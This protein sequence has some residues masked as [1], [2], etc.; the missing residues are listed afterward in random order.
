M[1]DGQATSILAMCPLEI[2]SGSLYA[3]GDMLERKLADYR[4]SSAGEAEPAGAAIG[5]IGYE[6]EFVFG[7]YRNL[8]VYCHETGLWYE[9]GNPT[10]L[11][12][13]E[14]SLAMQPADFQN[15]VTQDVF[16]GM[17]RQAKDYITAGDIYQVCLAYP[18]LCE[19]WKTDSWAFY[20]NFRKISPAP[21]GAFLR[22]NGWEVMSG[23]PETFLRIED[24][25]II[26][27]PIKGTSAR[28][29]DSEQDAASARELI[30]SSKEAAELTMITDLER[31]DLGRV[32]EYGSIHV[33]EMLKL[34]SFKQ[35]FH[36]AS[37]VEGVLRQDCSHLEALKAC[38]PGGSISGAPKIR[39]CQIIA[40]LEPFP[41]KIYTGAIGYFGFDGS[42]QFNIAIRTVVAGEGKASFHVG[43]GIVADSIPEREWQE[44]LEKASGIL[45]TA[46]GA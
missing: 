23:S 29:A 8:L 10:A 39:A 21:N 32:C 13:P 1:A 15:L 17:V 25:I 20:E 37:T 45:Q 28:H 46:R 38:F 44:T 33:R 7:I 34:E 26:T 43:A 40:E 35:V 3:D 30:A 5:W 2:L 41:R 9:A 12:H 31:N 22:L 42:S 14:V 4:L 18:F 36:L 24:R 6:G 11:F 27:R 16:C 19:E